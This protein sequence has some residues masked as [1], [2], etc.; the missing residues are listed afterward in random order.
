M[1]TS[2]LLTRMHTLSG[3]NSY[4]Y[5][6]ISLYESKK[7]EIAWCKLD[8]HEF[9]CVS[10]VILVRVNHLPKHALCVIHTNWQKVHQIIMKKLHKFICFL[11]NNVVGRRRGVVPLVPG[12]TSPEVHNLWRDIT[13]NLVISG[14]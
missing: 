6:R 11:V 10:R 1:N 4:E 8:W 14:M 13:T 3:I 7:A 5:T 9:I 12:S 2:A